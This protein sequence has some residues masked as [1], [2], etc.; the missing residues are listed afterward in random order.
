MAELVKNLPAMWETWVQSLG[1]EDP[2]E[3][4]MAWQPIPVFLPGDSPWT[5]EPGRLQAI[6]SQ[7]IR[8]DC[9]TKYTQ[10]LVDLQ[11]VVS[12]RCTAK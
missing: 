1:W 5:K 10:N 4:G 8:R 3:K 9:A 6:G 2:L 12:F 7:R 11:Y